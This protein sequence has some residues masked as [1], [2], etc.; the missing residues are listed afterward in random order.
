VSH[1]LI[2]RSEAEAEITEAVLWYEGREA[3]LGLELT[4]EIRGAIQRAVERP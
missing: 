2:V 3:G 4:A 1:R